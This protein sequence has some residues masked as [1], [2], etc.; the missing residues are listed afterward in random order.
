MSQRVLVSRADHIAYVTLNRPEKH[1]GIDA[2]MLE[3]LTWHCPC[4]YRYAVFLVEHPC[5]PDCR[6][7]NSY[8]TGCHLL[9]F[10]LTRFLH[11]HDVPDRYITVCGATG[12]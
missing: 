12:R 1:N 6:H 5:D 11:Q 4:R 2:K 7:G 10:L 8:R 3:E 9:C